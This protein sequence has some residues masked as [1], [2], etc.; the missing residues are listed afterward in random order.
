MAAPGLAGERWL[1]YDASGNGS[2]PSAGGALRC[3]LCKKCVTPL[4]RWQGKK[5]KAPAVMMPA[6]ARA[7]HLWGGSQ[8]QVFKDLSYAECKVIQLARAYSC[9][10]RVVLFGTRPG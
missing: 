6:H 9:V 4:R 7:N 1:F 10:K 3:F 5:H 2:A 8:P